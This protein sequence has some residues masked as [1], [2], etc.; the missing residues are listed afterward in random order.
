MQLLQLFQ[1]ESRSKERLNGQISTLLHKMLSLAL[2]SVK[3]MT[4]IMVVTV[5]KLSTLSNSWPKMRYLMRLA[6]FTEPEDV[7]MVL[8]VH[9]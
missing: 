6:Q 9:Q 8:N 3:E 4:K 5:V 2:K 1:I 7:I